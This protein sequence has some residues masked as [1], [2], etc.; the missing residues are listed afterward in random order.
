MRWRIFIICAVGVVF[1]INFVSRMQFLKV[2]SPSE[3]KRLKVPIETTRLPQSL[4]TSTSLL[5][6]DTDAVI[7]YT[8][9][10]S[11]SSIVGSVFNQKNLVTY[12]YEPLYPFS[13]ELPNELLEERIQT[14]HY[15]ATCQF[16]KVLPIYEKAY[17]TFKTDDRYYKVKSEDY[18]S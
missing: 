6:K 16:D 13:V 17:K 18:K 5:T 12:L 1:L 11:G 8:M 9:T 2:N 7:L 4:T 14:L 10:R 3:M 15:F